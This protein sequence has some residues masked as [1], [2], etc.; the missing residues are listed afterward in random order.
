MTFREPFQCVTGGI[1]YNYVGTLHNSVFL[2]NEYSQR[3]GPTSSSK[4]GQNKKN[5]NEKVS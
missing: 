1:T 2:K 3:A 5:G 4:P